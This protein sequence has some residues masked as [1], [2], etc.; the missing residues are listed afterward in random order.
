MHP[1]AAFGGRIHF[2]AADRASCFTAL[3]TKVAPYT[4][5]LLL[6]EVIQMYAMFLMVINAANGGFQVTTLYGFHDLAN[7]QLAGSDLTRVAPAGSGWSV[8]YRCEKLRESP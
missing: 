4:A 3:T 5:L 6:S 1:R 7:C 8:V 2:Q